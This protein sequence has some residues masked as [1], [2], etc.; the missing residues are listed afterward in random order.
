MNSSLYGKIEK[1]KRYLEEPERIAFQDLTVSFKGDNHDHKVSLDGE[2]W[3]CDCSAFPAYG[4]CSH[5]MAMQRM[6]SPMLSPEARY[7]P[8]PEAAH[9]ADGIVTF[10]AEPSDAVTV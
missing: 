7:G 9:A 4:T 2:K 1:A 6:L 8:E 3:S 10:S 5:V